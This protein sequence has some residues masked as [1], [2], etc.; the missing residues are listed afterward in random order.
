MDAPRQED[1]PTVPINV[2][3]N[4]RYLRGGFEKGEPIR[5]GSL[6]T[7]SNTLACWFRVRLVLVFPE[8]YFGQRYR[9][10]YFAGRKSD[11]NFRADAAPWQCLYLERQQQA[12]ISTSP[13]RMMNAPGEVRRRHAAAAAASA[14]LVRGDRSRMT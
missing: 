4:G 14:S 5:T 8:A 7:T 1:T 11:T 13:L 12:I 9:C 6:G 10:P 2:P 3:Q